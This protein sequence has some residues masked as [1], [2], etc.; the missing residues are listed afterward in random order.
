MKKYYVEMCCE[1]ADGTCE[2]EW[3]SVSAENATQAEEKV[4]DSINEYYGSTNWWNVENIQE[5]PPV[6]VINID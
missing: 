5:E 3:Y 6:L 2:H 4:F 1:M